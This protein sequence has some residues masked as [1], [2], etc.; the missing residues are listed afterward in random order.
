MPKR[1]H[2][3]KKLVMGYPPK[4]ATGFAAKFSAKNASPSACMALGLAISIGAISARPTAAQAAAPAAPAAA[5]APVVAPSE[6]SVAPS[7]YS[8]QCG[9]DSFCEAI[10]H[11]QL[12]AAPEAPAAE[13]APTMLTAADL[14]GESAPSARAFA[15]GSALPASLPPSLAE[16]AAMQAKIREIEQLLLASR[17]GGAGSFGHPQVSTTSRLSAE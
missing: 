2:F 6:A 11:D 14:R 3:V 13:P 16:S 8:Y 5:T 4:F 10:P 9:A 17:A 15:S 1:S 7:G 12:A